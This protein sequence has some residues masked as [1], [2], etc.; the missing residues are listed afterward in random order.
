MDTAK[1]NMKNKL[2][3]PNFLSLD[4]LK[5]LSTFEDKNSYLFEYVNKNYCNDNL[6]AYVSFL[7]GECIY[8]VETF[9][10]TTDFEDC[11]K[12]GDE[13]ALVTKLNLEDVIGKTEEEYKMFWE[14]LF[15]KHQAYQR[16][17]RRNKNKNITKDDSSNVLDK[18][19]KVEKEW[20]KK[21]KYDKFDEFSNNGM[22]MIHAK[23]SDDILKVES[24]SKVG[25]VEYNRLTDAILKKIKD[26]LC[27]YFSSTSNNIKNK[28]DSNYSAQYVKSLVDNM[29]HDFQISLNDLKTIVYETPF[30][31]DIDTGSNI[32]VD[33]YYI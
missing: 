10:K 5:L 18:T 23:L 32:Y 24:Y 8:R 27:N 14:R 33:I 7:P 2:E 4:D 29:S 21:P 17:I 30:T 3:L 15:A 19:I 22:D 28:T 9:T 1:T 12:C 6:Y 20:S 13:G 11:D 31:Y 16:F 25:D 26:N